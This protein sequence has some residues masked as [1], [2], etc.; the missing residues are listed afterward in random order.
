MTLLSLRLHMV[1]LT[2]E[3]PKLWGAPPSGGGSCRYSGGEVDCMRHVFI[4]NEIWVQN[5]IRIYFGRN[6]AWLK[7]SI[8]P[9]VKG[10]SPNYK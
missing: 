8:Y 7:Y 9:L 6:F 1:V 10:L 5:K 2:P 4:L 3:V